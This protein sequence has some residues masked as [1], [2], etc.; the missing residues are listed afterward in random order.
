MISLDLPQQ[1]GIQTPHE[2]NLKMEFPSALTWEAKQSG[3]K[4]HLL[5]VLELLI[6]S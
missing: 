3:V 1:E 6:I 5:G 4:L 2:K